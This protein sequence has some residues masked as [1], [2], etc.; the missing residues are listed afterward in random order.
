MTKDIKQFKKTIKKRMNNP[1]FIKKMQTTFNLA[2]HIMGMPI[3]LKFI[4]TKN[5]KDK[6]IVSAKFIIDKELFINDIYK[7]T[8]KKMYPEYMATTEK[9]NSQKLCALCE[10]EF[11]NELDKHEWNKL[12]ICSKCHSNI[13]N[14]KTEF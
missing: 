9:I 14:N 8:P 2:Y 7:D 4:E 6:L 3:K 12:I 10:A 11:I 5:K 13:K 1:N